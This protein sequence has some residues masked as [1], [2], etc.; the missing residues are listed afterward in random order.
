[1]SRLISRES[2]LETEILVEV[3]KVAGVDLAAARAEL[4]AR[5]EAAINATSALETLRLRLLR[6]LNQPGDG[7]WDRQLDLVSLL[8]PEFKLA[9]ALDYVE[10]AL[11]RRP[12]LNE[13][14]IQLKQGELDIVKTRNGL[15]PYMDFYVSLGRTG[16]ADSFSDSLTNITGDDF[17]MRMGVTYRQ[18]VGRKTRKQHQPKFADHA[19]TARGVAGQPGAARAG[20]CARGMARGKTRQ[21]ADRRH[22]RHAAIAG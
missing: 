1:M 14:R 2:R 18:S 16:Y 3:G 20:G 13:A 22:G 5:N 11:D 12:D 8:A 4:A 10:V 19:G 7:L 15:L 21:G 17:D 6:L 9:D